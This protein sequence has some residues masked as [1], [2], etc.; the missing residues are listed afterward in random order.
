MRRKILNTIWLS[1]GLGLLTAAGIFFNS[2]VET[3]G[4]GFSILMMTLAVSIFVAMCILY[5]IENI[6]KR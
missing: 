4:L 2:W 6:K 3:A 1:F 5:Y